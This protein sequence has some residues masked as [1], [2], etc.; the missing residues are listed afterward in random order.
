MM[1]SDTF[2]WRKRC[3][4]PPSFDDFSAV[5]QAACAPFCLAVCA[6]MASISG[7]DRQS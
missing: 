3:L 7:G 5:R 6:A 1:V 4:T 2:F